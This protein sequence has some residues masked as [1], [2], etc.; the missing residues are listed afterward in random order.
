MR[1]R[2]SSSTFARFKRSFSARE[3]KDRVAVLAS[4][5]RPFAVPTALPS[6]S[7]VSSTYA[8]KVRF[9]FC[10]PLPLIGAFESCALGNRNP[11]AVFSDPFLGVTHE[12]L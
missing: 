11:C 6:S 5:S 9:L 1:R 2:E 8:R 12:A 7:F 10:L 3:E 4:F